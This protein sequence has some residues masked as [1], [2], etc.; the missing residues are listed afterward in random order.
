MRELLSDT[1]LDPGAAAFM[2]HGLRALAHLDGIHTSELALVEEF[3][4]SMGVPPGDPKKFDP[5]GGGPLGDAA[6]KEAFFRTLQLMALADG[7]VSAREREWMARVAGEL[8]IP[9][10]RQA[11][12][13]V[14][15]RKYMLSSLAGVTAFREQAVSVGHSLG[16]T[17]AQIED[18]LGS[19]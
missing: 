7:R 10:A 2:A 16:L 15:A 12:L 4:R 8:G 6:Q 11:E 19:E 5:T 17:A 9:E 18:V 14:D 1:E 13:S 3:E